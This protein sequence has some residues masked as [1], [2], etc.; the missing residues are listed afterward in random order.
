MTSE[1]GGSI[2]IADDIDLNLNKSIFVVL[3]SAFGIIFLIFATLTI[4]YMQRGDF[5]K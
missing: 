2:L 4:L 1:N 3:F 5:Y